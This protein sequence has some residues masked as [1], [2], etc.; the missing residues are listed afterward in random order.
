MAVVRLAERNRAREP[1]NPHD[2]GEREREL[3]REVAEERR[4]EEEGRG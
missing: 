4:G 3:K 1:A 2:G